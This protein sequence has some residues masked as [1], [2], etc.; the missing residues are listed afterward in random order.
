[1]TTETY[2]RRSC[3]RCGFTVEVRKVERGEP[4]DW[5]QVTSRAFGRRVAGEDGSTVDLCPDCHRSLIEWMPRAKLPPNVALCWHE[6]NYVPVW[7]FAPVAAARLT[8]H[9][10]RGRRKFRLLAAD[11]R[12]CSVRQEPIC[13][14]K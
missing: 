2:D 4:K 7:R 3:D 11:E 1:M 12:C 10:P 9:H 14:L 8:H 5:T 6:Q 13:G